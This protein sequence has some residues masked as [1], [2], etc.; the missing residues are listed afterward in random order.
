MHYACP[1]Q[2]SRATHERSGPGP[3]RCITEDPAGTKR[4]PKRRCTLPTLLGS[5]GLA[6]E[7]AGTTFGKRDRRSPRCALSPRRLHECDQPQGRAIFSRFFTAVY[8]PNA[9]RSVG[10]NRSTRVRFYHRYVAGLWRYCSAS[11]HRE[12]V[13]RMHSARSAHDPSNR[14]LRLWWTG[15]APP[16]YYGIEHLEEAVAQ[17]PIHCYIVVHIA[18]RSIPRPV[19]LNTSRETH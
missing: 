19:A 9:R 3:S 4:H 18:G 16:L 14:R 6:S 11:W 17:Q 13:A 10:A 15:P 2:R 1:V 12:C 8:R 7:K 5:V